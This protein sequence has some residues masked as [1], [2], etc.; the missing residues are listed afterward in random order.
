MTSVDFTQNLSNELKIQK[1]V[2]D[3][4]VQAYLRN[5]KKLNNDEVLKNYT[6]LKKVDSIVEKLSK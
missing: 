2:S 6:F 3:S 1:N 5:L 4:T